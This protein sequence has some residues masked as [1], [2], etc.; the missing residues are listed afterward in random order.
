MNPSKSAQDVL[1]CHL[2]ETP[3]PPLCCEVCDIYLCKGCAGEHILDESTR[4]FVVPIKQTL[5][6]PLYPK[7]LNHS[8]KNC[9]LYCEQCTIPICVQCASS[10]EHRGHG[11]K[12][13][14]EFVDRKKEASQKDLQ[15]LESSILIEHKEFAS[16]I[17]NQKANLDKTLEESKTAIDK[18]G[19][20]LIKQV[21]DVVEKLKSDIVKK[22]EERIA[23]LTKA[24]EKIAFTISDIENCILSVQELQASRDLGRVFEYKSRN[25]ELRKTP[26]NLNVTLPTFVAYDIMNDKLNELFG[27]LTMASDDRK[28]LEHDVKLMA[29]KA[30]NVERDELERRKNRNEKKRH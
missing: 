15:G 28:T 3:V 24:E 18:H 6:V 8:S 27:S 26:Q 1:R 12:D 16:C 17:R 5:S 23:A 20:K 22:H 25:E 13:L 4:H 14:I 19:E 2:C 30:K 10:K 29:L 21:S 9:E 7:C 11:F